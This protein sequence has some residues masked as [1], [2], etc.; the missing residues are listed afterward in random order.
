MIAKTIQSKFFRKLP[1][2]IF[3]NAEKIVF[4]ENQKELLSWESTKTFMEFSKSNFKQLEYKTNIKFVNE[5]IKKL[6]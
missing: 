5:Q 4:T 2:H 1:D 6:K 3:V